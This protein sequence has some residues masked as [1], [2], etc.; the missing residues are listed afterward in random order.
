LFDRF[1]ADMH[2]DTLLWSHRSVLDSVDYG[3]VDLKRLQTGNVA[4][5]FFTIVSSSPRKMN[6]ERNERPSVTGDSITLLAL[7]QL[8]GV[9]ALTSLTARALSQCASLEQAA[10]QSEGRLVVVKSKK[11]LSNLEKQ[12]ANRNVI[13]GLLGIEGNCCVSKGKHLSNRL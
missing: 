6:F 4:L 13:G 3:H 11:D 9:R 1:I 12:R 8:W 10:Q 5:Q 2:A 7:A